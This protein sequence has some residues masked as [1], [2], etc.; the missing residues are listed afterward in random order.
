MVAPAEAIQVTVADALRKF[1]PDY[2][3]KYKQRMPPHLRK[4]LGLIIRCKTGELGDALYRCNDCGAKH[5]V[6]RSCGNRHCPNCQKEKTQ[7]WL[8]A[9]TTKLLPVQHFAV[10]FTVPEELRD[11]VRAHPEQG[12]EAIFQAGSHVIGALMAKPKN[13]GL[14]K[15]R[16]LR[17]AAYLGT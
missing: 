9:Q 11:F 14:Q 12:Y 15:G 17:S 4:V 3:A 1:A 10:T 8:A 6:G 7:D 16:V 5:W 2:L 13:L